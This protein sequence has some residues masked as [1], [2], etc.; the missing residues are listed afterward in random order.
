VIYYTKEGLRSFYP[1]T[2]EDRFMTWVEKVSDWRLVTTTQYFGGRPKKV[3]KSVGTG[4]AE[5][6]EAELVEACTRPCSYR[7][8]AHATST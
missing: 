5:P 1:Q 2:E 4:I 7:R 3:Q 8:A 6:T